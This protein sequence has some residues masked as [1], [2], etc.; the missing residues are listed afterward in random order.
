MDKLQTKPTVGEN[1]NGYKRR[2]QSVDERLNTSVIIQQLKGNSLAKPKSCFR[3][4]LLVEL[5]ESEDFGG[6]GGWF[7]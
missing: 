7:A 6:G 4:L 3:P 1:G 5:S 2:K